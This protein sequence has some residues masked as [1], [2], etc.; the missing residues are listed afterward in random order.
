MYICIMRKAPYEFLRE[1]KFVYHIEQEGGKVYVVGGSVRDF[2]LDKDSKDLDI[3]VTNLTEEKLA[4]ILTVH[5]TINNVGSS[6]YITKFKP[7]GYDDEID[8]SLPRVESH[9]GGLGHR[10]FDVQIDPFLPIEADLARRDLTINAMAMDINGNL[11]DPF[12]GLDDITNKKIRM[13]NPSAFF[14]DP[15][16]MLR[17]VAF[18][19]RFN[20]NIE[21][22][23]FRLIKEN[24]PRLS[25]I[26]K[27]RILDE[28]QK[29]VIKGKPEIGARLLVETGLFEQ[30]FKSG[31]SKRETFEH[32]KKVKTL[33]EFLYLLTPHTSGAQFSEVFLK[34]MKGSRDVYNEIK[35]IECLSVATIHSNHTSIF[36]NIYSAIQHHPAVIFTQ[37]YPVLDDLLKKFIDRELPRTRKDLAVTGKDIIPFGFENQAV[38]DV[39]DA[40]LDG[41]FSGKLRNDRDAL[42]NYINNVVL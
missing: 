8:I 10:A 15:L 24:A 38:G 19:A 3:L 4:A 17:A 28:L 40:L 11:I 25:E 42:L 39:I 32:F 14:D 20:F 31:K 9:N 33:A 5:G 7:F 34:E 35:A 13:A 23:T 36:W 18:A 1:F 12:N 29:I 41:I 22:E 37:I 26:S 6:F 27:E 30:V 16:R 2:F 21:P